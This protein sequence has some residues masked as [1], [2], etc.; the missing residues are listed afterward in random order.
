[1]S[2]IIDLF[3]KVE[4]KGKSKKKLRIERRQGKTAFLLFETYFLQ[5]SFY[6]LAKKFVFA[7]KYNHSA[8]THIHMCIS[9]KDH[10]KRRMELHILMIIVLIIIQVINR[11]SITGNHILIVNM[12]I[13]MIEYAVKIFHQLF[14]C[15]QG[16][17]G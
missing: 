4:R 15:D 10:A 14:R 2:G 8:K 9:G 13:N 11:L 6:F 12:M 1:M 3:L 5:H 16:N 7:K 17:R